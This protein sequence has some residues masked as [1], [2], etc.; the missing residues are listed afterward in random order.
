MATLKKPLIIT[1][2]FHSEKK[3]FLT[4]NVRPNGKNFPTLSKW[5]FSPLGPNVTLLHPSDDN[6]QGLMYNNTNNIIIITIAKH[7]LYTCVY[8]C[9]VKKKTHP[10]LPKIQ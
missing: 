9:T 3:V 4:L 10:K 5:I 7:N 1:E 8:I 2:F 6:I